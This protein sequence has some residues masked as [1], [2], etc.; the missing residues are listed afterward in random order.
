MCVEKL[1]CFRNPY[2]VIGFQTLAVLSPFNQPLH[3]VI[4]SFNPTKGWQCFYVQCTKW[5]NTTVSATLQYKYLS[6]EYMSEIRVQF[7]GMYNTHKCLKSQLFENRTVDLRH[8]MFIALCWP[9]RVSSHTSMSLQIFS[10][11]SSTNDVTQI[12]RFSDTLPPLL[13]LKEGFYLG[14]HT[15][16][17]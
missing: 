6:A 10:Q 16:C 5:F 8:L 3:I 9:H 11:N 2:Y 4:L 15:Q 17:H 14:L 12:K 1:N 13:N 7:S